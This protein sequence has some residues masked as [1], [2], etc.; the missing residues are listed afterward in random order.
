MRKP[1]LLLERGNIIFISSKATRLA[2]E[3]KYVAEA[4]D[5]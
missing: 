2:L 1:S 5:A 3:L 4:N